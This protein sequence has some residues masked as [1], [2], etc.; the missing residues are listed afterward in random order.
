M[1][2]KNKLEK[3]NKEQAFKSLIYNFRTIKKFKAISCG[4]EEQLEHLVIKKAKMKIF[5]K[6]YIIQ[7][8]LLK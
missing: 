4:F 2:Y 7:K 8:K 5:L 6:I 3:I 1:I